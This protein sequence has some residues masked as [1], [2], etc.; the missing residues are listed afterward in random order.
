M[1]A[2]NLVNA[3]AQEI[4]ALCQGIERAKALRA[5]RRKTHSYPAKMA[6]DGI[7][8]RG[9]VWGVETEDTE[10]DTQAHVKQF[11][12]DHGLAAHVDSD[13]IVAERECVFPNGRVEVEYETFTPVFGDAYS[14]RQVRDWLGY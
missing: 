11:I 13:R 9:H 6:L 3:Y 8:A 2:S 1:N 14:L 5:K 4:T 10:M 12:E 7:A